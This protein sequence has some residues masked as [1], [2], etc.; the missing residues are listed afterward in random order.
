MTRPA[1]V[2][3]CLATA[4]GTSPGMAAMRPGGMDVARSVPGA[5]SPGASR[6]FATPCAGPNDHSRGAR[7]QFGTTARTTR[8]IRMS[9]AGTMN[10]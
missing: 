1:D 5:L 9:V 10:A 4:A 6:Q 2:P 3:A 8:Q 7:T